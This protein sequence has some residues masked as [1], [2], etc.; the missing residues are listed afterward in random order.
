MPTFYEQADIEDAYLK[1]LRS[2]LLIDDQFPRYEQLANGEALKEPDRFA[3]ETVVRLFALCRERGLMCDVENRAADLTGERMDHLGKS[4]LVVLDYHLEPKKGD[5]PEQ[6]LRILEHLAD[7][8]HANLAVVY[9]NSDDLEAV[10]RQIAV[11]LRGRVPQLD[12][13]EEHQDVLNTWEPVFDAGVLDLY[14][15]G[16]S[17]W[18]HNVQGLRGDLKAK[19]IPQGLHTEIIG[20]AIEDQIRTMLVGAGDRKKG[21]VETSSTGEPHRWVHCQNVFIAITAKKGDANPIDALRDCILAWSPPPLQ[22]LLAHARN[23]LEQGGFEYERLIIGDLDRHV[24]WIY[25]A[26][27]GEDAQ[28]QARVERLLDRLFSGLQKQLTANLESVATGLLTRLT[29][30]QAEAQARTEVELQHG[31]LARAGELAGVRGTIQTIPVLHALNSFLCSEP[32]SGTHLRPGTVFCTETATPDTK[33][34]VCVAPACDM[35]PRKATDEKSWKFD[36][37]PFFPVDVLRL[38]LD[39]DDAAALQSATNCRHL[40][41]RRGADRV[42][43]RIADETT[44]LPRPETLFLPDHGTTEA[45]KFAA[46]RIR[47]SSNPAEVSPEPL[48]E[49]IDCIAVAQ[50]RPSY[51]DR[52]LQEAGFQGSRVGVDFAKLSR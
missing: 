26:M 45:S 15:N 12:F 34:W 39:T 3:M 41:I 14:L 22:V 31:H 13:P 46:Y 18:K 38:E 23:L 4:D 10:R 32:F 19:A 40:F 43:L 48:I 33:W 28:T 25:H 44:R 16:D 42:T 5:D 1:P 47:T 24:G 11:C 6:A 27:W 21:N 35:V 7:S 36:L 50:L 29:A 2:V 9:T 17:S 49:R 37:A 52:V 30:A 8:A 20:I 51:S